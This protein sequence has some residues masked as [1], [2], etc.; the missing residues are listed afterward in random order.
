MKSSFVKTVELNLSSHKANRN[1]MQ[2]KVL[3]I[4]QKD[5]KI[6]VK[7]ED[8]NLKEDFMT[9]FAQHAE[10]KQ[11]FLLNQS[12]EKKFCAEN[13]LIRTNRLFVFNRFKNPDF[14]IG[15]FFTQLER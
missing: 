14:Q 10:Q 7:Q 4:S 11:K 6:A 13:A 5:V 8:K 9:L 12:K 2:K 1:F 15:I 3:L